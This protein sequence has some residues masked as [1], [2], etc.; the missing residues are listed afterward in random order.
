M[1]RTD[2]SADGL[3]GLTIEPPVYRDEMF[4]KWKVTSLTRSLVDPRRIY[5]RPPAARSALASSLRA[6]SAPE[7]RLNVVI[8]RPDAGGV[9][10][11]PHGRLPLPSAWR[12]A[13]CFFLQ[14]AMFPSLGCV[15]SPSHPALLI[16][17]PITDHGKGRF[18]AHVFTAHV[19]GGVTG[20]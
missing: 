19:F 1:S 5:R 10:V 13:V 16:G 17:S 20:A 4:I 7:E 6:G 2:G 9:V 3:A 18:A 15:T 12:T 14:A 8:G 11:A